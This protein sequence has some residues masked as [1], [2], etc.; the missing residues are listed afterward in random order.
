MH[1]RIPLAFLAIRA[2]CWCMVNLSTSTPMCLTTEMLFSRWAPSLYWCMGLFLSRYRTLHLSMLNFIRFLSTQLS[3][4]SRSHWMA[5][6]TGYW[7]LLRNQQDESFTHA[8]ISTSFIMFQL[9]CYQQGGHCWFWM[10]GQKVMLA[11]VMPLLTVAISGVTGQD[12]WACPATCLH[13][14]LFSKIFL[15]FQDLSSSYDIYLLLSKTFSSFWDLFFS[16]TLFSGPKDFVFL[17]ILIYMQNYN[18]WSTSSL[19]ILSHV[20]INWMV[21][22]VPL[23][24]V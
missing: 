15:H 12:P 9:L 14:S 7:C 11:P 5:A 23:F 16:S 19:M 2:H 4:L 20:S 10:V 6:Q 21:C 18:T 13:A 3:S 22:D 24:S 8:L 1:P 17:T